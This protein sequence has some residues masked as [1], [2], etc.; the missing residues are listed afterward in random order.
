M[1]ARRGLTA[2]T[3]LEL[4]LVGDIDWQIVRALCEVAVERWSAV[5]CDEGSDSVASL[6]DLP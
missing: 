1:K 3:F 5:I 4:I 2:D 6:A